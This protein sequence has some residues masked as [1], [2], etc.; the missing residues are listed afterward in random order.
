MALPVFI[1][2]DGKGKKEGEGIREGMN[3]WNLP[4]LE[5]RKEKI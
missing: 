1:T 4:L 2:G 3:C 5:A